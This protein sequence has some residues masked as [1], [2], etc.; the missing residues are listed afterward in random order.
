[1]QGRL[2]SKLALASNIELDGSYIA[3]MID[4]DILIKLEIKMMF[5][6]ALNKGGLSLRRAVTSKFY[7]G[8]IIMHQ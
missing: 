2:I 6:I 3:L 1:M 4:K 5:F 8:T 7:L